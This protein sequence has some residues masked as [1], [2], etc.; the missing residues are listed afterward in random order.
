LESDKPNE[1]EKDKKRKKEPATSSPVSKRRKIAPSDSQ[2]KITQF[3]SPI[4]SSDISSLPVSISSLPVSTSVVIPFVNATLP[5][6]NLSL[7]P[8]SPKPPHKISTT[9]PAPPTLLQIHTSLQP[10]LRKLLPKDPILP[11]KLTSTTSISS[12][13]TPKTSTPPTNKLKSVD[14][15][16][17]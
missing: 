13:T 4:K 16:L 2:P 15:D 17:T 8:P 9:Y 1:S 7:S 14:M 10:P 6:N 12:P 11:T 5:N 3:V